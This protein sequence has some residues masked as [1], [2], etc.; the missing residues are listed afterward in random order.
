MS[1]AWNMRRVAQYDKD[2]GALLG[3]F[4]S[5]KAAAETITGGFATHICNCA[6]G[7]AKSAYGYIWEYYEETE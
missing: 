5:I 6:R 1:K 4:P 3:V 2:S 7:K